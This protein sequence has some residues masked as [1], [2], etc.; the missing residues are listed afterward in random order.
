MNYISWQFVV[1]VAQLVHPPAQS[2]AIVS[3]REVI[4]SV[5]VKFILQIQSPTRPALLRKLAHAVEVCFYLFVFLLS[6][7]FIYI[8]ATTNSV[9]IFCFYS[10]TRCGLLHCINA[11][12]FQLSN[13]NYFLGSIGSCSWVNVFAYLYN[14]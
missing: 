11:G 10:N 1:V 3:T 12:D 6:C 5:T 14:W 7:C 2:A 4:D 13:A 8:C 9:S